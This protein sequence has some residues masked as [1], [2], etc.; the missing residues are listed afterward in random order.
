MPALF[1]ARRLA[2]ATSHGL[3]VEAAL[4]YL[5]A[6]ARRAKD[7][8][9]GTRAALEE[10]TE[11]EPKL[12]AAQMELAQAYESDKDYDKAVSRYRRL[13]ATTP[14][15]VPALNNLAYLLAVRKG[16]PAEALGYAEQAN[17]LVPGN[18]TILDTLAWVQHLLGRDHEAAEA[19]PGVVRAMPGN[20][21]VRLHAAVVYAAVG[22]RE[23]AS[24]ELGEALR[25]D[26]ALAGGVEVK[27]LREQ[28]GSAKK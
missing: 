3:K 14:N 17:K 19:F 8:R 9:P 18:P 15:D 24:A 6:E 16:Q 25:L 4:A 23:Q 20:A 5:R 12:A 22:M 2:V 26:P 21:E 13:L 28:L 7:D 27:R 11:L 1:S 10:A